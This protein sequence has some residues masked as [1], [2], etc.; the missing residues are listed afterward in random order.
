M[1]R[2]FKSVLGA[3]AAGSAM[4]AA[5]P[6]A[7]ARDGRRGYEYR[8]DRGGQYRGDRGYRRDRGPYYSNRAYRDRGY[9]RGDRGYYPGYYR[10]YHRPYRGGYYGYRDNDAGVALAAGIVGIAIGAAI[11]SDRGR[12]RY[13]GY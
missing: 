12:D 3:L 6:A 11:A 7:E 10:A 1:N 13:Y 5:I 2:I 9:Y 4:V 8:G